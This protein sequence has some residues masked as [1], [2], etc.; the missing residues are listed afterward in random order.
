MK[1][2][3]YLG[4]FV[5]F[6]VLLVS[7]LVGV[8]RS[9]NWPLGV[10]DPIDSS[11][12]APRDYS[13]I[14]DPQE[15]VANPYRL[16]GRYGVLDPAHVWIRVD[17]GSLRRV[18]CLGPCLHFEKMIDAHTATYEI[19]SA[20]EIAL[21]L[22]DSDPPDV[23]R[24]WHVYVE[25]SREGT[26]GFGATI[27]VATLRFDGYGLMPTQI[28]SPAPPPPAVPPTAAPAQ[29]L[30]TRDEQDPAPIE[31]VPPPTKTDPIKPLEP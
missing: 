24:P 23:T 6:G 25:G 8:E 17:D 20:G 21:S 13:L 2:L 12:D 18:S 29:D 10:P 3:G 14:I 26:N 9:G 16:K 5:G 7:I 15:I 22:E 4:A 28:S 27:H 30:S 31:R 1:L 11:A 19:G